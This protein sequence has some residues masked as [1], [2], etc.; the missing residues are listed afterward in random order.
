MK[1]KETKDQSETKE[2]NRRNFIIHK[3]ILL[4]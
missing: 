4:V 1:T 2:A 3:R